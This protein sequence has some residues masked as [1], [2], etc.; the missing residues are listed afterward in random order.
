MTGAIALAAIMLRDLS[1][2]APIITLFLLI[3][4][5]TINLVV[6]IEQTLDLPTF[7]PTLRVT[8]LVPLVGATGC[9]VAMVVVN[10]LFASSRSASWSQCCSSCYGA[11]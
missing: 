8:R 6:L 11:G 4:Y 2:L 5:A 7:R 1:V 3:T 10:T 9:I